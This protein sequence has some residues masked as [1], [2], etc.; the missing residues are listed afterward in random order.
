LYTFEWKNKIKINVIDKCN[1][2]LFENYYL[3]NWP[4][5]NL[6][7]PIV[8]NGNT[9][10]LYMVILKTNLNMNKICLFDVCCHIGLHFWAKNINMTY[11]LD[12]YDVKKTYF[13]NVQIRFC[14]CTIKSG[15]VFLLVTRVTS[16]W[17]HIGPGQI[18]IGMPFW[19]KNVTMT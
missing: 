8:M 11:N 12:Q 17:R 3:S 9:P 6:V 10:Q 5:Q 1:V 13:L 14:K 18:V 4:H 2:I 15:R 19:A 16:F 7:I